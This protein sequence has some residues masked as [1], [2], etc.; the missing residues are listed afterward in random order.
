MAGKLEVEG[1]EILIKSS[2]GTMAV[3]PK[4]K[5]SMVKNHIASGNHGMV[6][7][8]VS[9][10]KEF[11]H[12]NQKAGDGLYANVHAK[13]QRIAAG[14][15]ERMRKPGEAG[16]P[17]ASQFKQAAK[18][19]KAECGMKISPMSRMNQKAADGM[20]IPPIEKRKPIVVSNPNDPR[21]RAYQDSLGLY[22]VNE[23]ARGQLEQ[24]IRSATKEFGGGGAYEN[25]ITGQKSLLA[26]KEVMT[27][28]L[29]QY[30]E[31]TENDKTIY[32]INGRT[33]EIDPVAYN[34]Y[35]RKFGNVSAMGKQFTLP[36][37]QGNEELVSIGKFKKPEQPVVFE[38]TV[39]KKVPAS[40][41]N[42]DMVRPD[43]TMKGK[44]FFGLIKR[45]DG[46]VSSEISITTQDV[47]PGKETLI[48]T[49]V[50]TLT[51][52]EIDHLLSGKYNPQGREG[53][54]DVISRKA[55]DFARQR[56]AAK[57]PFFATQGE[58]G[59]FKPQAGPIIEKMDI[60]MAPP[61]SLQ[62]LPLRRPMPIEV[63]STEKEPLEM[64]YKHIPHAM[65][66]PAQTTMG[67]LRK[68]FTGK[69]PMPYWVDKDGTKHY[70]TN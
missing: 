55:I 23:Q 44:G 31:E 50:P 17:T 5:V 10:L 41:R 39:L 70:Q 27:R 56:A 65:Q 45:P 53:I 24:R 35:T 49:M 25:P 52:K 33:P 22:N 38:K 54:D 15:G 7:K 61:I 37:T 68:F 47:I 6:D 51:N 57:K 16:A 12:D 11:T 4:D 59:K 63:P 69:A 9:T 60:K 3:I 26:P 62:E 8:F 40:R 36:F 18:T 28:R 2:N 20:V 66:Y 29:P 19:A 58:E 13:R 32:T 21:L 30:P 42:N 34:L 67:K 64:D 46:N 48:P 14:S 1:K 43:G